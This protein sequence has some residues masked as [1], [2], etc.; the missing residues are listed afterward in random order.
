MRFQ[1][2]IFAKTCSYASRSFCSLIGGGA[3]AGPPALSPL[4]PSLATSW[5]GSTS[6]SITRSSD[7]VRS[8]LRSRRV[9]SRLPST[10]SVPPAM[11][12]AT[13]TRWNAPTSSFGRMGVS[14][15]IS[16]EFVQATTTTAAPRLASRLTRR[17][18]IDFLKELVVLF[19]QRV[20]G[21]ELERLL[22]RRSRFRQV[23]FVFVRDGQIVVRGG[24]GRIDLGRTLPAV[25]RLSP[26]PALRDGDAE[27]HLFLRVRTGVRCKRRGRKREH[28]DRQC[29]DTHGE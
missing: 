6:E 23:A 8:W 1:Y 24:V 21:L 25:D 12:P 2:S 16:N 10:S 4:R 27:L 20:A 18:I 11:K 5:S 26:Q 22:V 29:G 3:A 15:G 9:V 17:A 28:G 7:L 14:I 19:D 13:S